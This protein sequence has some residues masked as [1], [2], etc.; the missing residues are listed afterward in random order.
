VGEWESENPRSASTGLLR[1]IL[2][3]RKQARV[4]ESERERERG[5]IGFRIPIS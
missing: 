3:I 1:N 2:R 4:C 5:G